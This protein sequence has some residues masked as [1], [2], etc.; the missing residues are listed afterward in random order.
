MSDTSSDAYR[1][2]QTYSVCSLTPSLRATCP[3]GVPLAHS[4]RAAATWA[5][6]NFDFFMGVPPCSRRSPKLVKFVGTEASGISGSDHADVELERKSPNSP[7]PESDGDFYVF[8]DYMDWSWAYAMKL[9]GDD[10][11]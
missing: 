3:T 4:R 11:G 10:L 2:F 1:R 6:V 8:A 5:S 9:R 7:R